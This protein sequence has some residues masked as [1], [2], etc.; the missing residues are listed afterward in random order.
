MDTMIGFKDAQLN[1]FMTKDEIR[2]TAPYIFAT[3]ATNPGVSDR[4]VFASTETVIE[5]MEK[6][7][8][9]VV[10]CKQQRANKNSTVR[11][12]HMVAFQN[13]DVFITKTTEKGEEVESY[14][15]VILTNSHDGFNSFKFMIGI[16][17]LVCSNGMVLATEEFE[18]ISIRHINYTFEELRHTIAAS[19]EKVEQHVAVMNRMQATELTAEQRR[20]FALNALAIRM[21]K[22][23]D[24]VKA[25]DEELDELLKP[26]RDEDKGE[27]LWATFNVLQEKIIK[28]LYHHGKTKL[29]KDRKARPI[30][31]PAKDIMVNQ[32]LFRQ[33]TSYLIAA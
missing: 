30:T 13:P 31:G 8:W 9:G 14:P 6:L 11:S 18:S 24:E 19:I 12:F 16:F 17:R 32:G 21:D 5:D 10:Q 2:R 22:D 20:D 15:Q 4:Y 1:G 25:T 28:G 23:I 33:A 29:G 27:N 26:L 3:K 7:G